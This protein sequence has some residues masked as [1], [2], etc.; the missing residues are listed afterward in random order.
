[1]AL[2]NRVLTHAGDKILIVVPR[3][4]RIS[5][6]DDLDPLMSEPDV[7][8][9]IVEPGTSLPANANVVLLPG[10]KATLS[11]LSAL[12]SEGWDIDILAHHRR[13][14]LIVGLC[15]G[16]Q[17]LGQSLADPDGIEGPPSDATGLGLLDVTTVM[18]GDKSLVEVSGTDQLTGCDIRG[19]EMHV[20]RTVG[21]GTESPWMILQGN[22]PDGAI[23]PDGRVMACYL[24]GIFASD[25]FRHAFLNRI[26]EGRT[27]DIEYEQKIE[28]ALDGLADHLEKYIDLDALLVMAR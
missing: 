19:Y 24:H 1:M 21:P 15:G 14:G 26:R 13:G 3:L 28:A 22:K 9:E 2:D 23:S 20:G 7:H 6:F 11:D 12:R 25:V 18:G 16:Y 17:M 27:S 8:V 4:P 5:N 10:S